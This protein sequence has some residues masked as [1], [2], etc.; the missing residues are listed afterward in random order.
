MI[1]NVLYILHLLRLPLLLSEYIKPALMVLLNVYIL[2]S[3]GT[4]GY[5]T[6]RT[7]NIIILNP[8]VYMECSI[9]EITYPYWVTWN[10]SLLWINNYNAALFCKVTL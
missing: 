1:N 10:I 8:P 4:I 7:Y 3:A 6:K 2:P 9:F 5:Y